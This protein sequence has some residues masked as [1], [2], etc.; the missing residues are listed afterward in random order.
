MQQE[1]IFPLNY[2]ICWDN[3]LVDIKYRTAML[4]AARNR[5]IR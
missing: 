2:C 5:Q 3:N 4:Y 1:A